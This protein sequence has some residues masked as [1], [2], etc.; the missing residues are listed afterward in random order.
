MGVSIRVGGMNERLA[1]GWLR[2]DF[3]A[4]EITEEK[5]DKFTEQE[6]KERE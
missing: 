1:N 3:K 5:R 2:S 6:R 4:H